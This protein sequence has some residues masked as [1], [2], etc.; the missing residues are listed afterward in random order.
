MD[1]WMGFLDQGKCVEKK[2][3]YFSLFSDL[4]NMSGISNSKCQK[5]SCISRWLRV[6]GLTISYMAISRS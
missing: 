4:R 2:H 1:G 6:A 3:R 5:S